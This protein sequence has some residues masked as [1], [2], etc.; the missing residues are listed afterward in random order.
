MK[1]KLVKGTQVEVGKNK[2]GNEEF[3][4]ISSKN[5]SFKAKKANG[6]TVD[7]LNVIPKGYKIEQKF[8]K[9]TTKETLSFPKRMIEAK[10][11]Q[12]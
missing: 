8:E 6:D 10:Y 7:V 12:F 4:E 9:G 2:T 11:H 3:T 5:L 1:S